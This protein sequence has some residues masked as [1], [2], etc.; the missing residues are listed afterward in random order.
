MS[1]QYLLDAFNII[2][3]IPSLSKGSLEDQR[4]ALIRFVDAKRPQGSGNNKVAIV[5]DG[6]PGNAPRDEALSA[7][8]FYSSDETADE[9]IMRLV[10]E[11]ENRKSIIVVTNDRPLQYAVKA[12]GAKVLS[13]QDFVAQGDPKMLPKRRGKQGKEK[14][15]PKNIPLTLEYKINAEMEEIWLK[16]DKG[17]G[18]GSKGQGG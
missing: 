9:K 7:R 11:A 17:Q 8:I 3:Q 13:V 15:T 12:L 14:E 1:L 4:K 6:G 10:D 2:Y 5:F 16:K 18:S